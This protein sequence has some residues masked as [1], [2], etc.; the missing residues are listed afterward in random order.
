MDAQ[1]RTLEDL[2]LN[3][4]KQQE[5]APNLALDVTPLINPD[6]IES[7]LAQPYTAIAVLNRGGVVRRDVIDLGV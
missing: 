5:R 1:K 2:V 6:E 7:L 4:D 3:G